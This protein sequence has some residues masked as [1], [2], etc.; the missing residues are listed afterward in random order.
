MVPS[1]A[2]AGLEG[3]RYSNV[4]TFF[5]GGSQYFFDLVLTNQTAY[6]PH[7][8]SMNGL[9]GKFAQVNLACNQAVNLRV[10]T[11]MSCATAPSCS[12]CAPGDEGAPPGPRVRAR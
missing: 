6:V 2:L 1:G 7:D 11:V 3:I 12:L 9:R 4:G 8:A 10:T 5:V